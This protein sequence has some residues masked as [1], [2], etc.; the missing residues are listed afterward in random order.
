MSIKTLCKFKGLAY[1]N[2]RFIPL[3]AQLLLPLTD[4]L[5]GPKKLVV[6]I[7][8]TPALTLPFNAANQAIADVTLPTYLIPKAHPEP[9]INGSISALGATLRQ[10]ITENC[11]PI[12]PIPPFSQKLMPRKRST[13]PVNDVS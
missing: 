12:S 2:G 11:A 7:D 10:H 9:M 6:T 3:C 8:W 1:F 5:K 4:I 13:A